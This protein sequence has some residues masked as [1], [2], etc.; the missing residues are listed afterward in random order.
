MKKRKAK[1]SSVV[2]WHKSTFGKWADYPIPDDCDVVV[3][4]VMGG[5]YLQ[6]E[7]IRVLLPH[8]VYKTECRK[9]LKETGATEIILLPY[10]SKERVEIQAEEFARG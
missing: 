9:L 2:T 5:P 4:C 3:L 1:K 8:Q 10:R 6:I 7:P